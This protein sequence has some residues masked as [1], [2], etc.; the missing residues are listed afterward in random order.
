MTVTLYR[1]SIM[2]RI[3]GRLAT[4]LTTRSGQTPLPSKLVLRISRISSSSLKQL[5]V[6]H[7]FF[8]FGTSGLQELVEAEEFAAEGAAVG[9][10][11]EFAGIEM[12]YF[13]RRASS[14][15]KR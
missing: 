10:P 1:Q 11:F 4:L 9:G 15:S 3:S 12:A 5:W 14:S 8:R 7:V 6:G 13:W 2:Q